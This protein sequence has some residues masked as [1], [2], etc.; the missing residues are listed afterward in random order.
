MTPGAVPGGGSRSAMP[1]VLGV[2]ALVVLGLGGGL[3]WWVLRDGD[4]PPVALE[5]PAG[6][7]TEQPPEDPVEPTP[8]EDPPPVPPAGD[9]DALVASTCEAIEQ[10]MEIER[11]G[12][13]DP[14]A[15]TMLDELEDTFAS[16]ESDLDALGVAESEFERNVAT[17]CPEQAAFLID[18]DGDPGTLRPACEAGDMDA[19]DELYVVSPLGS[20][21][22]L[23]G[24]TCG[25]LQPPDTGQWCVDAFGTEPGG[26]S[27]AQPPVTSDPQLARLIEQCADG[28]MVAC[29]DLFIESPLNSPEEDF[30]DTCGGRQPLGTGEWCEDVFGPRA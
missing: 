22:R 18:A 23:F 30:G 4:E 16:L 29:D 28:D 6:F 27:S 21:D 26:T 3:I 20:D 7:E 9:L 1:I 11:I 12:F 8:P 24:D 10:L 13:D 2:V 15:L 17:A 19:C 5:E 14:Q 25:G